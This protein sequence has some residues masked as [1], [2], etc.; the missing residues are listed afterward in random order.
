MT[1]DH[2][3]ILFIPGPVEVDRE[4]RE[5]MAMPLVGH[6]SGG[7]VEASKATSALLPGLFLTRAHALFENCPATALMEAGVRN[8]VRERILHLSCGAFGER[9]VEVSRACGRQPDVLAVEWGEA[10]LPDA[11]AAKLAQDGPYDAVAITHSET[12]TGVLNPLRELAAVIRKVAPQTLILVDAVTSLGGAEL[13]FDDWGIDLAFAGTQKCLA[14][15]PGLCVFAVSERAMTTAAAMPDR[16]YLLDF[17]RTRDGLLEGKPAATPCV[18]LVFAL[19][20]QLRRIDKEGIEARWQRHL[21]MRQAVTAWAAERGYEF[22]V[23]EAHRSPTVSTLRSS[24]RVVKDIIARARKAGFVLGNGYGKLKDQ[25]F[26]IG[27]MGDH[28][29]A[30]LQRLLHAIE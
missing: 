13:R 23:D 14:L 18:P 29:V 27:H 21:A 8:L 15:P 10:N 24:G 2:H 7:F 5:I 19:L 28:D 3:D 17:V 16:G 25:T 9:W 22:L 20:A 30:R 26:R 6:R 1:S 12:S 11:L 4:L